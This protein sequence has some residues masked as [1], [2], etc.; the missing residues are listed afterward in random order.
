MQSGST[1]AD[2]KRFKFENDEFYLKT[3]AQM[4]ELFKEIPESC[5]NTLLIAERCNVKLREDENLLP[6]FTVPEAET[7]DSWLRKEA[8]R[9]LH[10]R[11]KDKATPEHI[12]RLSYELDVMIKMG[13]PGYFLVVAD[14]VAHAK[15][16]GGS[17]LRVVSHYNAQR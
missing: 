6:A 17:H 12:T 13:F 16:V 14:L 9:G 4:R 15:K 11:M 8:E 5:D 3:P 1:L 7:E 2:P 10:E